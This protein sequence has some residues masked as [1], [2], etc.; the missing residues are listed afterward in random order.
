[1]LAQCGMRIIRA[2]AILSL[3][4]LSVSASAQVYRC[5]TPTG[6]TEFSQIPC[7]KDSKLIQDRANSIDTG[8][9]TDP[10]GVQRE[11]G[12]LQLEADYNRTKSSGDTPT[13]GAP[14]TSPS[15]AARQ[16]DAIACERADRD[17]HVE[18]RH[19]RQ[20]KVLIKRKQDVADWECGR[21]LPVNESSAPAPP[22][23]KFI[24]GPVRNPSPTITNCD[25][26]GCW[27]SNGARYNRGGGNTY[28]GPNGACTGTAGGMV[29]P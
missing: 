26:A 28:F 10:F 18:S 27:D 25:G 29:C 17:A 23:P 4:A 24:P 21:T 3:S 20:D 6:G 5:T 22:K 16:I 12:R 14:A 13:N 9:P 2:F 8:P 11:R 15:R 19:A 7:G 1:M